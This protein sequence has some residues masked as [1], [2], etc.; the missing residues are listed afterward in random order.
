MKLGLD[1]RVEEYHSFRFLEMESCNY[2]E[3]YKA[4]D[5][6]GKD[7]KF[8]LYLLG[9]MPPCFVDKEFSEFNTTEALLNN[10]VFPK[11]IK[12][13]TCVY[14][15]D[16]MAWMAM[17][18]IEGIKLSEWITKNGGIKADVALP[19]FKE[20]LLGAKDIVWQTNGGGHYNLTPDNIIITENDG[21]LLHAHIIGLEHAAGQCGGSTPFDVKTISPFYR[22]PETFMGRF[23]QVSDIYSL[24]ILLAYMLQGRY[25][26]EVDTKCEGSF[27]EQRKQAA[28]VLD[29]PEPYEKIVNKC[30]ATKPSG[31]YVNIDELITAIVDC[32][33]KS[34]TETFSGVSNLSVEKHMGNYEREMPQI[35]HKDE[36]VKTA[37]PKTAIRIDKVEG[38]GFRDVA[39]MRE[40]KNKL[41]RDFV[42]ILKHRELAEKYHIAPPNGILLWG[43]PGTGKTYISKKLAEES[44]LLFS[45]V[46]PSDLGSIYIHGSQGMIADLF[47]RSEKLAAKNKCGVL[48]VFDEFDSLVPKRSVKDNNQSNEVAEFLTRL[49]NC[50]ERNVFVIATTNRLE[51]IDPAI[52]RKGRMD[53]IIYVGLPDEEMRR[54][55]FEMELQQRPHGSID[56]GVLVQMT[57]GYSSGD[58]SYVVKEAARNSFEVSLKSKG[59]DM[60]EI[61][62]SMLEL[63]IANARPSIS[64]E[65]LYRY[66]KVNKFYMDNGKKERPHIG[67]RV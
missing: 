9:A 45:L 54:E 42:E 40:L 16:D 6:D 55:L 7:V 19:L 52:I 60:V 27:L 44:G 1:A 48:L 53:E 61:S 64:S 34:K 28:F 15:G 65:E 32:M 33:E 41:F 26:W 63:T 20:I 3:V 31:R 22:A 57:E 67:F 43:P 14:G 38:G 12:Q 62:Q 46:Q 39:G 8:V 10:D 56:F 21:E 58:I 35:Q 59:L 25:P 17:E 11:F 29:I 18:W 36:H 13:D 30:I 50:A 37:Q 2:R 66:E 49:D 4:Q 51:A 47:I 24:G 5:L 23:N